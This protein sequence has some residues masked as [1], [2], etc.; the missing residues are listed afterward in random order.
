MNTKYEYTTVITGDQGSKITLVYNSGTAMNINTGRA[1]ICTMK[2]FRDLAKKHGS[3]IIRRPNLNLGEY[4]NIHT[5]KI[6]K[7]WGIG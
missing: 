1:V 4:I 6:E 2:F 3:K 7:V 5:G